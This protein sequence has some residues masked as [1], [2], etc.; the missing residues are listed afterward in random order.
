M[1]SPRLPSWITSSNGSPMPRY[2]LATDTTRRRFFS[3]RR[4]LARASPLLA[5]RPR[6]SSSSCVRSLPLPM[7]PRYPVRSSGAS[8]PRPWL[9]TEE[10]PGYAASPPSGRLASFVRWPSTR[11]I[12]GRLSRAGACGGE[13][14]LGVDRE[15][16][17]HPAPGLPSSN[18]LQRTLDGRGSDTRPV[19]ECALTDLDSHANHLGVPF[20]PSL[21]NSG[22]RSAQPRPTPEASTVKRTKRPGG[23]ASPERWNLEVEIIVHGT[24]WAYAGRGY[25]PGQRLTEAP[26]VPRTRERY[27]PHLVASHREASLTRHLLSFRYRFSSGISRICEEGLH[28]S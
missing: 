16:E 22:H 4:S 21:L 13:E 14:S 1:M 26:G 23:E 10:R 19:S 15:D 24:S 7:R 8:S 28:P 20:F 18:D 27:P 17:S 6:S 25:R 3:I 5:R 12:S 2:F 11:S 9:A